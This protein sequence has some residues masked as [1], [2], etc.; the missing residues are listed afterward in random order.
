VLVPTGQAHAENRE[1]ESSIR[2]A[3]AYLAALSEAEAG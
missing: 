2:E 3:D 1:V